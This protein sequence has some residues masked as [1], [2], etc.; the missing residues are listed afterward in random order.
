MTAPKTILLTTDFSGGCDRV[1][2]RAVQLTRQWG[3][4]LFLLHVIEEKELGAGSAQEREEGFRRAE[5]RLRSEIVAEDI[6]VETRIEFGEVASAILSTA[7]SVKANLVM[8][9]QSQRDGLREHLVGTTVE[10][11]VRHADVPSLVVK[12]RPEQPYENI[13]V[14]TDFSPSSRNALQCAATF[15]PEASITLLHAYDVSLEN[16]RGREGPAAAKQA[17]IALQLQ[18]FLDGSDLS[19]Q[20]RERIDIN[21]DYGDVDAVATEHLN[22]TRTDLVVIGTHGRSGLAAAVL[23]STARTVLASLNCDVLLV[24]QDHRF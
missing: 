2:E 3:A 20:V 15:F 6:P 19:D 13:L 17:D 1:R 9:A 14:G 12:R 24:R 7:D 21:V 16:I 4:E 22:T 18:E 10:R 8:L 5:E 11:V 23:G